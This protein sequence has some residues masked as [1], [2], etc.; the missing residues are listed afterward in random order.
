MYDT[1]FLDCKLSPTRR[2]YSGTLSQTKAGLTCQSWGSQSPHSHTMIDS[3]QFPDAELK[4]A[5]NY[6]RIPDNDEGGPWC[7]TID[8]FVE[9]DYCEIPP[10][11]GMDI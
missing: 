4:F 1:L 10:C 5:Q 7:Y 3:D 6:C 8:E 2:E 11:L 9:K